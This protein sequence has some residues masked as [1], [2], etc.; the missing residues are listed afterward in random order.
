MV[1]LADKAGQ[2]EALGH[3]ASLSRVREH[4][5][6]EVRGAP[7]SS[8]YAVQIVERWRA[9]GLFEPREVRRLLVGRYEIR[10]EIQ[11]STVYIL[12]LWHTREE[13]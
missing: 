11:D 10:Y 6:G 8:L 3:E 2:V 5:V 13:R 1:H 9:R 7:R 4:L 12:R